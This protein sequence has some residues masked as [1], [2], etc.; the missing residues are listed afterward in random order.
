MVIVKR[1]LSEGRQITCGG[2]SFEKDSMLNEEWRELEL[3]IERRLQ[4]GCSMA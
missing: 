1:K 3:R 2:T 4:D